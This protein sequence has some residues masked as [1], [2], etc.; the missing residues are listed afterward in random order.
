MSVATAGRVAPPLGM[1]GSQT[2]RGSRIHVDL[3]VDENGTGIH[4]RLDGADFWRNIC[5]KSTSRSQ[6]RRARGAGAFSHRDAECVGLCG[7]SPRCKRDSRTRAT[8]HRLDR[9][10]RSNDVSR[11][12]LGGAAGPLTVGDTGLPQR[13]RAHRRRFDRQA[14]LPQFDQ[15]GESGPV[16]RVTLD[17]FVY[18]GEANGQKMAVN[19]AKG[20]FRFTTGA[21][22]TRTAYIISTPNAAIG[23]RGTVLDIDGRAA[24]SRASRWSRAR[25]SSARVGPE[26][27]FEQQARNCTRAAGG[28]HGARCDCVDLNHAGQTAHGQEER[29]ATNQ[30]SLTSTPVN[31]ASLCSGGGFAL[32]EQRIRLR[33]HRRRWRR[34]GQLSGGGA[35]RALEAAITWSCHCEEQSDAAIQK[36]VGHSSALGLLRFARNDE[37]GVL[38]SGTALTLGGPRRWRSLLTVAA[39]FAAAVVLGRGVRGLH[40][41]PGRQHPG[42]GR[43]RP[44]RQRG[45]CLDRR[46]RRASDGKLLR[47]DQRHRGRPELGLVLDLRGR[48]Q[49]S[50]GGLGWFGHPQCD[51]ALHRH[52][53]GKRHGQLRRSRHRDRFVDDRIPAS[54]SLRPATATRSPKR[55]RSLRP[56]RLVRGAWSR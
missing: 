11:E 34:L 36:N 38:S 41:D 1:Q 35:M 51:V 46:R 45:L 27:T 40:R 32:L 9:P 2:F 12:T 50:S 31:F 21:S 17:Q 49:C 19:L 53:N 26:V 30:A 33:Q 44:V 3:P 42:L 10:S 52:N 28:A 39:G 54:P 29:A 24:R 20:I 47:P 25:R 56:W 8:E 48:H 4:L 43:P 23:V 16:S 13:A 37:V 7:A 55:A 18:A 14:R 5:H 22:S 15:S 6:G